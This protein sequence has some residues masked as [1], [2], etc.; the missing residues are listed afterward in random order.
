[1]AAK[2][3]EDAAR[4]PS[5]NHL[6]IE[7]GEP[8]LF[9]ELMLGI[10]ERASANGLWVGALTNGFW[11]VSQEKAG[12]ALGPLAAAGLQSLSISTDA[13]HEEFVPVA[14]V[15]TAER[16]AR[17]VGIE[18]DVMVCRAADVVCRGRAAATL[19]VGGLHDWRSLT[20]CAERLTAPGRVHVGPSGE[21]HL[22]QGLLTGT[23]AATVGLKQAL[24]SYDPSTHP[25]AAHLVTGGPAGLAGFAAG[26]G[27]KPRSGYADGCQLCSEVRDFLKEP[28]KT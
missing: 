21:I 20:D 9:P 1:L 11:A 8:F 24:D 10:V 17:A 18:A 6:F 28:A 5:V 22:C 15:Q 12:Q 4:M 26:F 13:W 7:G 23:S 25:V 19:C 2:I 16:A 27:W 3:I 14:K